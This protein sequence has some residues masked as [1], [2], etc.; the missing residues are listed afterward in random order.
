MAT[1]RSAQL[2]SSS[3]VTP[4]LFFER[5][6][7]Q[8]S[9]SECNRT[10]LQ[11]VCKD[12]WTVEWRKEIARTCEGWCGWSQKGSLHHQ[13]KSVC[14]SD[15]VQDPH[16][17]RRRRIEQSLLA[18][19]PPQGFERPCLIHLGLV[20]ACTHECGTAWR[21]CCPK[22]MLLTWM[23]EDPLWIPSG[24]LLKFMEASSKSIT[25]GR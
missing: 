20:C 14:K 21:N 6:P 3:S 18:E 15:S 7:P 11:D 22:Q 17:C 8:P 4:Q 23:P 19:M 13:C 16:G 9:E 10:L 2:Q 24:S 1:G 12:S 25:F 5:D